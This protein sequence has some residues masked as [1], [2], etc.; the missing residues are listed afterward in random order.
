MWLHITCTSDRTKGPQEI[1]K[2]K[3]GRSRVNLT[4]QAERRNEGVGDG[5][6]S[7]L[8]YLVLWLWVGMLVI[9]CT[10]QVREVRDFEQIHYF[11][12][13]RFTAHFSMMLC[14]VVKTEDR[15]SLYFTGAFLAVTSNNS[16]E[17]IA[18][19]SFFPRCH[20]N[21]FHFGQVGSRIHPSR[22]ST[23]R[24]HNLVPGSHAMVLCTLFGRAL[25]TYLRQRRRLG[26]LVRFN[27]DT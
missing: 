16:L 20:P 12:L 10:E 14:L 11:A 6:S 15:L 27:F 4:I 7:R 9:L 25:K 17:L 8:S 5:S 23:S 22:P 3:E 21:P 1:A 19:A 2:T 24:S 13:L 18:M 26:V